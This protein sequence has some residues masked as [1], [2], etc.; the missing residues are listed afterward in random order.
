MQSLYRSNQKP[1]DS[2]HRITPTLIA[3]IVLF[4]VLVTPSNVIAF[5][6]T[7][8]GAYRTFKTVTELANFF[9]LSNFAVNFILYLVINAD[10]R[11]ATR[12]LITCRRVSQDDV[13]GVTGRTMLTGDFGG[14]NRRWRSDAGRQAL[15]EDKTDDDDVVRGGYG[16]TGSQ[17]NPAVFVTG[18][19][20]VYNNSEAES[21]L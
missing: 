15:D 12:D 4:T 21:A 7:A 1:V 10:F 6:S 11:R 3:L 18:D 16:V 9:L 20:E 8:S 5:V 19:T 14:T 13:K 2:A 17:R